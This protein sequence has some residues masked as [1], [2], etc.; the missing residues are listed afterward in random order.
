MSYVIAIPTHDRVD[1]FTRKTY[2]LLERYHLL[3]RVTLF[4]QTDADELAYTT[5]FPS[6]AYVRAPLG[7]IACTNF[8]A[9]YYPIGHPIVQL[10]D[11]I[12]Q[13][14]E[15]VDG[16]C[17]QAN[18]VHQIFES[19]FGWMT[20]EG[21]S[22][23]GV[24]PMRNAKF[25]AIQPKYTT[26]LRF[27]HDPITLLYNQR[28]HLDDPYKTDWE[29]TIKY[30]EH[31]GSVVRYN[32]VGFT[33]TYNPVNAVGGIGHRS[34]EV[35]TKAAEAF[36]ARYPQY[37]TSIRKHVDGTTS[38]NMR[39]TTLLRYDIHHKP[40]VF[41]S[42]NL[43]HRNLV[44]TGRR[45][46]IVLYN[47]DYRWVSDRSPR[48]PRTKPFG[49]TKE[50]LSIAG[51]AF[52]LESPASV[53]KLWCLEPFL[54]EALEATTF[55]PD[56]CGT[57]AR[58]HRKYIDAQQSRF[59]SFGLAVSR[60]SREYQAGRGIDDR[61]SVNRNNTLHPILFDRLCM[62]LNSVHPNLFGLT[63]EYAF[64]SLIVARDAMCRFH[65]DESNRGPAC[66]VG[67]GDYRGG[68][69]LIDVGRSNRRIDRL[70][71]IPIVP[72]VTNTENES[73]SDGQQDEQG[74]GDP[75]DD[76]ESE[77]VWTSGGS[78]DVWD[79]V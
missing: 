77:C 36:Q 26:D 22:L 61:H 3:D 12:A 72:R 67:V 5:A 4:L 47:K 2:R 17:V 71:K 31:D 42:T 32:H 75:M 14:Y 7:F 57:A 76:S 40:V 35:E 74:G 9:D 1:L 21:C 27:I 16:K 54:L 44:H 34:P 52:H 6:L 62:Y 37:I 69:L 41:D 15:L 10:H 49:V 46:A 65:L 25:M 30:Y 59:L 51:D 19:V 13:I 28:I 66:I 70:S 11:D 48:A 20:Q 68:D 63:D 78:H 60:K 53:K 55:R 39:D 56:R 38:F 24:Y 50:R 8:I 43:Y 58:P 79:G 23:G 64:T 73:D 45:Y 33:T 29:R 18:D